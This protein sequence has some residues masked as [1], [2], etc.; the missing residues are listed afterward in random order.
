MLCRLSRCIFKRLGNIAIFFYLSLARLIIQMLNQLLFQW[1]CR[2]WWDYAYR[3][4]AYFDVFMNN[5]I[6]LDYLCVLAGK[7]IIL[8]R[9][10]LHDSSTIVIELICACTIRVVERTCWSFVNAQS[11]N[12]RIGVV[13]VVWILML[14]SLNLRCETL[15]ILPVQPLCEERDLRSIEEWIKASFLLVLKPRWTWH[16][17]LCPFITRCWT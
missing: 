3:K 6:K 13:W 11:F 12:L 9:S 14:F 4:L 17:K 1:Y 10:N 8:W 16:S 5:L 2:L 7:L 15:P